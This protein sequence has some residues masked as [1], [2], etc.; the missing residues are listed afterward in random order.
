MAS[1]RN[2]K[3]PKIIKQTWSEVQ[4]TENDLNWMLCDVKGGLHKKLHVF[5]TGKG[6]HPH[7]APM[8]TEDSIFFGGFKTTLY[9]KKGET[10]SVSSRFIFFLFSGSKVAGFKKAKVV[11]L[12][13]EVS[14][15]FD[16]CCLRQ[17]FDGA[18]EFST[19]SLESKLENIIRGE[20]K[21]DWTNGMAVGS[22]EIED[23]STPPKPPQDKTIKFPKEKKEESAPATKEEPPKEEEE[24][25]AMKIR[26]RLPTKRTVKVDV[27]SA[28]SVASLKKEV[29]ANHYNALEP[30]QM[31]L[32]F[33]KKKMNDEQTLGEI[34]VEDDSLVFL[35]GPFVVIVQM[36]DGKEVPIVT[37]ASE[38]TADVRTS[39]CKI[40]E[41]DE[42]NVALL[43]RG[44]MLVNSKTLKDQRIF[45][46]DKLEATVR[47]A[48]RVTFLVST[49]GDSHGASQNMAKITLDGF[50]VRYELVD[51]ALP[52][53]KP[54]RDEL[55]AISG[56]RG[57]Y[58]QLFVDGKYIG[59]ST[60][61]SD[62]NESG[63][64]QTILGPIQ[65]D[66][67]QVQ[68]KGPRSGRFAW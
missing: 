53:F 42:K 59:S 31:K 37:K 23:T 20:T 32:T 38:T 52:E 66:P 19:K 58:P 44:K 12:F 16:N 28:M 22:L 51:G 7:F 29:S 68:I 43:F 6:G 67:S 33:K 46:G 21:Y 25:K 30:E 4:S 56:K 1:K 27:F 24:S 13:K 11:P 60:E 49:Y 48:T 26:V 18:D 15:H 41:A 55:F 57:V 17:I 9:E 3:V 36:P 14:E 8:M 50:K 34:G 35:K 61:I 64:L 62:L 47:E 40:V 54:R 2:I 39:L 5:K 63:D 45:S 65:K 10:M